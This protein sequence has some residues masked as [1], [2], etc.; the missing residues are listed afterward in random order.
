MHSLPLEYRDESFEFLYVKES[1]VQT[2]YVALALL[3]TLSLSE[4]YKINIQGETGKQ[5]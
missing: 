4:T 3:Y 5:Q 2:Q 1:T